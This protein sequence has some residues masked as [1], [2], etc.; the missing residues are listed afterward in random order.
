MHIDRASGV[1]PRNRGCY[2]NGNYIH[3]GGGWNGFIA[4]SGAV[5][6]RVD[7]WTSLP[8]VLLPSDSED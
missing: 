7:L 2:A 1:L 3:G 4:G 6:R 8:P 5:G